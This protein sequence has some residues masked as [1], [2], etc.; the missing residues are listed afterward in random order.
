MDNLV[1][2]F[3]N[4]PGELIRLWAKLLKPVENFVGAYVNV[5]KNLDDKSASGLAGDQPLGRGVM[6]FA[7]AAFRQF[8]QDY[9]RGNG[10]LQGQH[11]IDGQRVD[12]ANITP[13]C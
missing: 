12:P 3:G 8:V 10:L 1:G 4:V 11:E 2:A 6:P 13:R 5:W 7:G 9:V